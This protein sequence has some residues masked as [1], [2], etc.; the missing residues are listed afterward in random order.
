[1]DLFLNEM[2]SNPILK[3]ICISIV[4]DT[5]FGFLKA[6]KNKNLNS[7]FG[8]N[9]ALRKCGILVASLV[10]FISDTLININLIPFLDENILSYVGLSDIGLTEFFGILFVAYECLSI[11]SNMDDLGIPIP[12][13]FKSFL[14]NWVNE[15]SENMNKKANKH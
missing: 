14:A 4:A 1:M 3:A 10:L 8:I 13:G 6:L 15:H 2:A 9:G 11:L 12:K 5:I 7:S